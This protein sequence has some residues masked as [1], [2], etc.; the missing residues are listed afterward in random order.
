MKKIVKLIFNVYHCKDVKILR[1][2]HLFCIGLASLP[3]YAAFLFI[4]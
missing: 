2:L 3:V 1:D 4:K